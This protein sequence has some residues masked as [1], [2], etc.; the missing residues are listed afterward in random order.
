MR[1]KYSVFV[2]SLTLMLAMT[3]AAW[4][5][6]AP[7]QV[8]SNM[9]VPQAAPQGKQLVGEV[10]KVDVKAKRLTLKTQ[11]G[12][13]QFNAANVTMTGYGSIADIKPGDKIAVLYE[14][15]GGK[16]VAKIIA[17]HSAMKK[18]PRPEAK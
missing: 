4:S 8:P 18:M 11:A 1:K 17:N 10:V 16:L 3:G 14:E 13:K 9:P 5:Q 6:G 2:L 12:E 7:K 15:K